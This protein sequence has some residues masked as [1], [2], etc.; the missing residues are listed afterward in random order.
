MTEAPPARGFGSSRTRQSAIAILALAGISIHLG[1][2]YVAGVPPSQFNLPLYAVLAGGSPPVAELLAQLVRGRFGSDLL[3]GMSIVT[4]LVLGEYLAGALVVLMLAGGQVLESFA[5]GRASSALAALARRMPTIAHRRRGPAVE[6]LAL[7]AIE[8]DDLVFVFPHEI[9]PVDGV[10]VE[11]HGT[12]DESYLTGEPYVLSK[13]PGSD[14]LSGAINGERALTVRAVRRARDSRHARIMGVMLESE[15]RRPV[16]RRL[17][18]QL[19]AAYTPLAMGVA[20]AAWLA[21]GDATRFLAVLVVATPCPLLIG[22]PIAIVGSI[23]VAA[24]RGI[25]VRD[26]SVLERI[27]LCRTIILDKT[28]TLTYGRPA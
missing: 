11:G 8:I 24:R 14:V 1:L 21:S 18:D 7:D 28:G 20:A 9:C 2:R 13:A 6:D 19:G 12:M 22:I 23:S 5:M 16:S 3:S 4:S 17:G 15:Q 10:V 27:G 26:P 25:V